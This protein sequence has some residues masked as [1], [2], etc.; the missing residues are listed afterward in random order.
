MNVAIVGKPELVLNLKE[1]VTACGLFG[2]K[3]EV[4]Q[5]GFRVDDKSDFVSRIKRLT[6]N[7]PFSTEMDGEK[8]R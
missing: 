2:V 6:E 5:I 4:S 7:S 8:P 1:P 3:R